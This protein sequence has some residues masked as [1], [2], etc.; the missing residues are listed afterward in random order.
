MTSVKYEL[1]DLQNQ[2]DTRGVQ[3]QK[4]GIR[5]YR[6]PLRVL[7]KHGAPQNTTAAFSLYTNIAEEVKGSNM[8]RFSQTIEKA[9]GDDKAHLS[10]HV[11]HEIV[12]IMREKLGST[13]AYCKVRFPFYIKKKAPVSDNYAWSVFDSCLEARLRTDHVDRIAIDKYDL[14]I[15]TAVDYMSVCPCSREMS[16][17]GEDDLI[18]VVEAASSCPIYNVLKRPDEK[19]VTEKG[20]GNPKFTED[21][22]RDVALAMKEFANIDGFVFVSEHLESIHQ[23]DAVSVVRGGKVHIP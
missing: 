16:K 23:Y 4:V 20:Y 15:T 9:L 3:L 5:N 13:D 14:F 22:S 17:T 12:H 8:S 10:I 19:F 2:E 6:T 11:I 7:T 21:V 18:Y 1:P